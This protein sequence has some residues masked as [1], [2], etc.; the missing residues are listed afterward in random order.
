MAILPEERILYLGGG[1]LLTLRAAGDPE[2]AVPGRVEWSV[3]REDVAELT[4]NPDGTA[5]LRPLHAGT[6]K[7]TATDESGK[8]G[9]AAFTAAEPVTAVEIRVKGTAA[10]GKTV[11][12]TAATIPEKPVRKDVEWRIDAG[13]EIAAIDAKGRLKIAKTAPAG[14]AITVTCRALGAPEPVEAVLEITVE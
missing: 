3:D 9:T 6:V 4:E 8:K 2:G 13:E 5:T 7:V 12:L 1:Q 11:T 10:P 14:T